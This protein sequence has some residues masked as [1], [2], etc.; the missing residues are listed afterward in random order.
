MTKTLPFTKSQIE[1]IIADY[2]TPFHL[3][4]EK[5]I[6]ESARLIKKADG[7][8]PKGSR[9][10]FAIKALPNPHIMQILKEEGM[11]F[12]ASSYPEL[13]LCER[14][15][16]TGEDIMFSSNET[17]LLDYQKAHELGAIIN[18]DDITHIPFL[19]EQ[20]I[21]PEIGCMRYNPGKAPVKLS[22]SFIIGNPADA[23]YGVTKEQLFEGYKLLKDMGVKR[24]GIH[25]MLASN[26]LNYKHFVEVA[27]MLL[28]VVKE[29]SEKLGITFEFINLGG[30][31]GIPYKPQEQPLDFIQ[32]AEEIAKFA[33]TNLKIFT[34]AGRIVTGPHGYLITTALRLKHTYKEYVG[35]DACMTNLMRPGMYGAYHHITVLGKENESQTQTY[36]VVGGLCENNDKFAI[37]RKLP[38]VAVG[39]ILVIHDTGAH[40]HTMGFNYNGKLKSA[41][42]LLKEDGSVK[43]IRRA[44][45]PEDLFRTITE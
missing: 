27:K 15:S 43:L 9:N 36:D 1:K 22:H 39:D 17:P 25:T 5:G 26:E 37:D 18:I 35:L 13:L 24:F 45:T 34:E 20:G 10:F 16:V 3:Y 38:K 23:K 11:G 32:L 28:E 29:L 14:I 30:G 19:K 21:I 12:D 41:E 6:R 4:D 8:L 44:E 40:G 7:I 31:F 2:P 33:P 42:L